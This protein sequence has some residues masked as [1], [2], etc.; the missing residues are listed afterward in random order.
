MKKQTMTIKAVEV[1]AGDVF[2]KVEGMAFFPKTGSKELEFFT[3]T[4]THEQMTEVIKSAQF[5][6]EYNDEFETEEGMT[7]EQAL[8]VAPIQYFE[9]ADE[10]G[11]YDVYTHVATVKYGEVSMDVQG[12]FLKTYKTLKGA[13]SFVSKQTN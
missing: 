9:I 11:E 3:E 8:T 12:E 7:I 4:Y 2:Y 10:D 13:E 6:I 1:L 5:E